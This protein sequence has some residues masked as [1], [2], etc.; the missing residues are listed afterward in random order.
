MKKTL[1]LALALIMLCLSAFTFVACGG[2]DDD[3]TTKEPTP[4]PTGYKKYDN[5][6]IYFGY[7]DSW[8]KMEQDGVTI[9]MGSASNNNITVASEEKTNMYETMDV[10]DFNLIIKPQLEGQGITVS[11]VNISNVK[12]DN[13][14]KITKITL[15][16]SAYGISMSQTLFIVS[17]KDA[18]YSVTVTEAQTE[19]GLVDTIFATLNYSK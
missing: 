14:I 16:A 11:N 9:I 15:T 8:G 3:T 4:I 13:G 7:P 5:G 19:P 1:A 6:D 10:D 2:D 18:T 12:N 17:T